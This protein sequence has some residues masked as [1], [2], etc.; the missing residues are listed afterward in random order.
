M[1][2]IVFRNLIPNLR[3]LYLQQNQ[4]NDAGVIALYRAFSNLGGSLPGLVR[5]AAQSRCTRSSDPH[6]AHERNWL[7]FGTTA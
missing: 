3:R 7:M 4:I 6:K 5:N 2:K 1:T